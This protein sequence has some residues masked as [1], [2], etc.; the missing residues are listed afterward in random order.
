M[1]TSSLRWIPSVCVVAALLAGS[2]DGMQLKPAAVHGIVRDESGNAV[3]GAVVLLTDTQGQTLT[4]T[5]SADGRYAFSGLP[6]GPSRLE[7][8][9]SGFAPVTQ[10]INL[11]SGIDARLDVVVRLAIEQRVEVISSLGDFRRATGLGPVGLVLGPEHLSVLPNDPDAMLLLLRELTATTGRADEVSVYVD[12]QRVSARLPPKEAIQSIR[13]STNS[14]APEFAEPSAGMVEIVTKPASADFRGEGQITFNDSLLNAPNA[15]EP[16]KRPSRTQGYSG[17]FGGP[18]VRSR[19]SLLGYAGQWMRDEEITV[20]TTVVNP[21][22][23]AL[24]PFRHTVGTPARIESFSLRTDVTATPS[25]LVS[26][27]FA[28]LR[29]SRRNSRLES[30][31]DLPER[32]V[33]RDTEEAFAR[34]SVVSMFGPRLGNEFR[35]H[36]GNRVLRDAA[37][38]GAPAVLV[39][40]AF[41]SGGNQAALQQDRTTRELSVTEIVSYIGNGHAFRGGIRTGFLQLQEQRRTNLG[42]TFTFGADVDEAGNLV[43]TPIE[44][45]QRTLQGIPGYG[46]STFTIAR[47]EPVIHFNDWQV[48]WFAQDDL[49]LSNNV[50]L[51]AGLR[52]DVQK[53]AQS[54]WL[55]LAP[56]VGIAWTPSPRHTVRG[57]FGVFYGLI[58]G[59]VALDALRYDGVGVVELVVD[60]PAFFQ[61]IP[62]SLEGTVAL[63]TVRLLGPLSAPR[64]IAETVSYEWQ[65]T[66]TLFASVGFTHRRGDRL[67][68]SRNINAPDLIT[69]ERPRPDRGPMLQFESTGQSDS[70]QL[71]VTLRRALARVSLFGTYTLASSLSDTDGPYTAPA[72]SRTLQGEYG[73]A[74]DD[75]RHPLVLGSL[76][77]VPHEWSFSSL[78]TLGSGHPFNI[79]TGFDDDNDL[80]FAD[81]PGVGLPGAPGVA[82]TPLGYF[83]L[84]R[85]PLEPMI[86]RNTGQGP[87]SLVLNIG[88]AKTVRLRSQSGASGPYLII[89]VSA[90]NVTNQINFADFN[91]V[92]TSPLFGT[93]NR[94]LN[95]RRIE[96]AARIGF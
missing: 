59:D 47:G 54:R 10:Q 55:D 64:T 15:F 81:R 36:A 72:D 27:E 94:A 14:F 13:I 86:L 22:T 84:D 82:S 51:S 5:T 78:L 62:P 56:R 40:D 68:R 88:L 61:S 21:A 83:D 2:L 77:T 43:A 66:N 29:D 92:V 17:Y 31:L 6:P 52:H 50:I 45:Y 41:Y 58:P 96:L 38:T 63:P 19:W 57:A 90:E 48:S 71:R 9:L 93:A 30:G 24:Q 7:T 85:D 69:G 67:L 95:P 8:T 25:N 33:N 26:A 79:T 34:F 23:F 74:G 12:G 42:G 20:N 70:R 75:E 1:N 65:A 28:R 87:S 89:A 4:V 46:P 53:Q 80:L 32:G 35:A 3:P 44:R 49:R 16:V 18:I 11:V 91:G 73:R 37:L 76:V 60:R 39:L